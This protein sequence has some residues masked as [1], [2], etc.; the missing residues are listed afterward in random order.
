M[1]GGDE[2]GHPRTVQAEDRL[3]DPERLA[4]VRT[5]LR[6]DA[7][8]RGALDH[9]TEVVATA[10]EAPVALVSIVDDRRQ[11]FLSCVGLPSAVA[12]GTPISHSFCQHVVDR[13][14]PLI[15]GDA[16][17]DPLVADNPSVDELNVIAYAGIP[18]RVHGQVV[19]SLCAIDHVPREWA[20]L[21]IETLRTTAGLV[22]YLIG[23]RTALVSR[24]TEAERAADLATRMQQALLAQPDPGTFRVDLTYQ[25]GSRRLLLGG[26]FVATRLAGDGSL[27]FVIGDVSGH[28]PEAAALAVEIRASWHALRTYGISIPDL[29]QSLDRIVSAT[30]FMVTML[31]GNLEAGGR[32]TIGTAGHPPPLLVGPEGAR[33]LDLPPQALLGVA[34]H[35]SSAWSTVTTELGSSTL[36]AYTDG[37]VEGRAD[38]APERYGVERLLTAIRAHGPVPAA[39]IEQASHAHGGP[40][41]DDV[42]ILLIGCGAPRA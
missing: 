26:D 32:L 42:A 7:P 15:V 6:E 8:L 19:G 37:L 23:T 33:E 2:H 16:R 22:E 41:P 11:S 9:V 29:F 36:F 28:G 5:L 25:A 39:L 14:A 40:L 35:G 1:S 20:A 13:D 27:D 3:G 30:E 10:L 17:E 34:G 31:V 38:P 18:L 24:T 12:S 21:E 4:L